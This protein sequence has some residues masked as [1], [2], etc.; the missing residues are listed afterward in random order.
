MSKIREK[1]EGYALPAERVPP[2]APGVGARIGKVSDL[3]GSRRAVAA[4]LGISTS[5]LQRYV[6]ETNRPPFDICAQLCARAA[7]R[8]E[9]LATGE[10]PMYL[11]EAY[12][13]LPRDSQSARRAD[14]S[15]ESGLLN[16]AVKI[17]DSVLRN[18]GLR[19]HLTS[20]QFADLVQLVLNDLA[21]GAAD[22]SAVA[23][24]GRILAI[25]RKP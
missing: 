4:L 5:A 24:L 17:T 2:L 9:W 18:E 10:G 20:A 11:P 19:D 22:D 15:L 16:S 3:I 12:A 23:S 13:V 21:R 7:V 25:N 8:M 14:V 1:P 6:V